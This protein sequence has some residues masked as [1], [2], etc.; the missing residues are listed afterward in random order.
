MPMITA[1]IRSTAPLRGC[2]NAMKAHNPAP[3][4]MAR[5]IAAAAQRRRQI[6]LWLERY[7]TLLRTPARTDEEGLAK[8]QALE[9]MEQARPH[10]R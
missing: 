1:P 9:M 2:C 8:H 7:E 5:Q 3:S 10:A 6:A 4:A